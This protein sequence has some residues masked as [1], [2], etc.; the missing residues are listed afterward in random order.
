MKY[1]HSCSKFHG[2]PPL[3]RRRHLSGAS[4]VSW[5][6]ERKNTVF[7]VLWMRAFLALVSVMLPRS[8]EVEGG[9]GIFRGA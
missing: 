8:G 2:E 4:S 7:I 9:K 1:I 5:T 6:G 3:Y